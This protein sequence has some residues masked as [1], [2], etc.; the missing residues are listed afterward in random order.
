M[1]EDGRRKAEG[2]G[3]PKM[4]RQAHHRSDR[5][6]G[7]TGS[8]QVGSTGCFALRLIVASLIA[9]LETT[10]RM[11]EDGVLSPEGAK[12]CQPRANAL[13]RRNPNSLPSPEGVGQLRLAIA[14]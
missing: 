9:A 4:V 5:Q 3:F 8:P 13:G 10:G 7:S 12:P 2:G 11:G 6:F 14:D 1:V